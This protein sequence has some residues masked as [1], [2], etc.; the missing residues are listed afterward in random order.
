MGL[1]IGYSVLASVPLVGANLALLAWGGPF[2]G[3]A[4][5]WPRMYVTHVLILPAAIATLLALHLLLVASRHHTQ[6]GGPR[7]T[8]RRLVGMP[9]FPAYA[10]RSLGLLL[11]VAAV[12]VLLGGL[13]QINPIWLW[14]PYHVALATNGAQPDW[15]LGWLIGTLRLVPGFDVVIGGRT[16]V[17]NPFWGGA[18]FPAVV[19]GFLYLWPWLERRFTGDRGWANVLERPRDRAFRTGV[20]V[21][22]VTWLF[23][24]FLAGS[25]DRVSVS[26]GVSYTAQIWVYRV[27]FLAAPLVA[28]LV[29]R[30]VCR[31]LVAG[32]QVA[33]RRRA[34]ERAASEPTA[35]GSRML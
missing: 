6:F 13:A 8:Q 32:E 26:F 2:P 14:G 17:P 27:L 12:L 23:V 28:L 31:E 34:A 9:M 24:V 10:P 4:D 21:A 25:A 5:F 16:V 33:V 19:F 7:R 22:L 1:A 15:Y 30:R 35:P 29:T 3:G 18:L 20:G 11:A